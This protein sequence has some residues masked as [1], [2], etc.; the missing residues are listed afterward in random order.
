MDRATKIAKIEAIRAIALLVLK[1]RGKWEKVGENR[2]LGA[3]LGDVHFLLRTPFQP[4]PTETEEMSYT[5]A[6]LGG[7]ANLPFGLDVWHAHK[8]VLNVEWTD[9]GALEVIS[10]HPGAW[11]QALRPADGSQARRTTEFVK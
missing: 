5:R 10:Y 4:L 6:L 3:D 9:G 2:M 1:E 11:E 8:K 7:K